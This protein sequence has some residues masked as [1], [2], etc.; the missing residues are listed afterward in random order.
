MTRARPLPPEE[1]RAS[2]IAAARPVLLA[3]G[4]DFTTR[5]IADAAG[6]AEGT[7]FR[8]FPTRDDLL[9]AVVDAAF[10]PTPTCEAIAALPAGE[11]LDEI[12]AALTR[13]LADQMGQV[14]SLI[15][16]LHMHRPEPG[17][18]RPGSRRPGPPGPINGA[19][20][21]PHRPGPGDRMAA[22]RRQL[23][24]AVADRLEPHR[25]E[26]RVSVSAAAR[27]VTTVAFSNFHPGHPHDQGHQ[28]G[29]HER[30]EPD[31]SHE[32]RLT[33]EALADLLVH[34]LANS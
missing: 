2:I 27:L 9:W 12:V 13:T 33:P 24:R 4:P 14:T 23:V 31:D 18:N 21:Q 3:R 1:R 25:D 22:R 8:V 30:G 20:P 16:A 34:G 29:H 17:S 7:I 19:D 28:P 6:I 32:A 11:S 26:L 15:G 5:E 10:D